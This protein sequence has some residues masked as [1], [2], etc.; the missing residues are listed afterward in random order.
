MDVMKTGAAL[1]GTMAP[2]GP[3]RSAEQIFDTLIS[4]F[5][6]ILLYWYNFHRLGKRIDTRG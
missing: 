5:G 3:D 4:C 2:E 1:L 6:G